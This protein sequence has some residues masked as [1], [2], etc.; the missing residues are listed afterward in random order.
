LLPTNNQNVFT[1]WAGNGGDRDWSY[2]AGALGLTVAPN[3]SSK[4]CYTDLG[5]SHISTNG[6]GFWKQAY[7]N[8]ADQNLTNALITKGRNYHGIGLEDTSCWTMAWADSNHIVAG[9]T[10][11]KGAI[12]S[13]AGSSWSFGYTGDNFNTMYCCFKHPASGILY[14]AVSSV[15]DMYQ[16]THLKDSA[17]D[18][19]TG[20]ILYST[21]QGVTWL[22]LHSTTNIAMWVAPDP[23]N[24]NRL[25]ASVANST[26][27]GIYVLSNIQSGA[28]ATLTK[29]AAPTNTE[30]HAFNILVLNDGTLVCTYSGRINSSGAFTKSSGVFV[31]TNFG[32]SWINRSHTNMTYWTKDIVIDTNDPAQNTWYVGVF[33]GYGGPPNGLGGLYKTTNRGVSWTWLNSLD[34]VES[35]AIN[36][37]NSNELYL[38][39]EVDGMW[40]STNINAA[41]PTFTQIAAY[42]FRQPERIFFNPFNPTEIWATSFGHGLRVGSTAASSGSLPGTLSL[43]AATLQSNGAV[44]LTLQQATPGAAYA[45]QASTAL[46]NWVALG[47]N[48][49]GTNGVMQFNDTN[50]GNSSQRFYRSKAQ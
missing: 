32:A 19:G 1:G 2:G 26:N 21:N 8:P 45:I 24:T 25:Y 41:T 40:I 15:H 6:G 7:V 36:P 18:T 43:S 12:S 9:Y 4:V 30:G 16:S 34:R 28:T 14:A 3:D 44:G 17:I 22:T 46:S 27:G 13:D 38:T 29:L 48:N 47:T 10:D 50:A 49:A 11:I 5:F 35:C 37:L 31:S 20:A 33:S 42:P 23:N 39:T